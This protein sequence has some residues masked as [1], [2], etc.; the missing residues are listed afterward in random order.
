M[1]AGAHARGDGDE[2]GRRFLGWRRFAGGG[3]ARVGTGYWY[4]SAG[5][6][7]GLILGCQ[8]ETREE[9]VFTDYG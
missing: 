2:R 9:R 6:S 5:G 1:L 7:P 3:Y 4:T 8:G